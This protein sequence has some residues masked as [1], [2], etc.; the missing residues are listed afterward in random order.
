LF[1]LEHGQF[2]EP[3][4]I[5]WLIAVPHPDEARMFANA[6][7]LFEVATGW[8]TGALSICRY[9]DTLA[10]RLKQPSVERA[11]EA[12]GFG[13]PQGQRCT[14]MRALITETYR[15]PSVVSE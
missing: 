9:A 1:G 10:I 4:V 6:L 2:R 11:A 8:E 13:T 7:L 14:A 3:C 5:S 15:F 12:P